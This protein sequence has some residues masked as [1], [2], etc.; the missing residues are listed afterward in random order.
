[1]PDKNDSGVGDA[2]SQSP[3]APQSAS[4]EAQ[5]AGG[6]VK[7]QGNP[8]LGGDLGTCFDLAAL[9]ESGMYRMWF[10]W[11]PKKSIALAESKDGIHWSRPAIALAPNP[12]SGWEDNINRPTVVKR[13]DGY[14]MWYTGQAGGRSSIGYTTSLD[15]IAWTR[16]SEKPALS[17]E[18]TWEKGAVMCPHAIWNAEMRVFRM[19]YSGGEQYEPDAIGYASSRDGLT[20]NKHESNPIFKPQPRN[21]WEQHK[22]AGCQVCRRGEWHVMFYIGFR[23]VHHAQIGAARSKDGIT[24]WERHPANPI[25]R[26]GKDAWD[27]DACYKPFAIFDGRKWLLWYNGRRDRM[28]QIGLAFHEGEDLAFH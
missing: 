2:A 14:H 6:W 17:P 27:G 20:W 1:M 28:E 18:Q 8:V 25:I 9:R 4:T 26:P 19:W 16:M 23:D 24:G 10:S 11:R 5:T 15:G 13:D 12:D 3:S 21:E 22:V 7:H